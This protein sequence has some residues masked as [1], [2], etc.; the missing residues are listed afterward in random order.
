MRKAHFLAQLAAESGFITMEESFKYNYKS[1]RSAPLKNFNSTNDPDRTRAKEWGYG[2]GERTKEQITNADERSIANWA[3]GKLPKA[4]ELG[5][6]AIT[7]N[8]SDENAD[9]WN[10]R[11]SGFIQ[12]TG[13]SNFKSVSNLYNSWIATDSSGIDKVDLVASPEDLRTDKSI[14]MGAALIYWKNKNLLTRSDMGVGTD[15]LGAITY[16]I[17]NAFAGWSHREPYL[18]KAVEVLKVEECEDYVRRKDQKGSVVVVTGDKNKIVKVKGR[19]NVVY[20]TVVYRSMSLE[21]YNKLKK[22]DILPEPD[23]VTYLTRDTH[24]D[25][26]TKMNIQHSKLRYG[27]HNECPPGD[28]YYLNSK[29]DASGSSYMMYVSDSST[30]SGIE[31]KEELKDLMDK[32]REGIA[33]HQYD[34]KYSVGCLTL[35]SSKDKTPVKAL[36]NAIPDL[37]LHN[38]MKKAKR[39]DENGV[40]HNMNIERRFVRIII[41]EREVTRADKTHE[42]YDQYIWTGI[43]NE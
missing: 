22:D 34:R 8:W 40:E 31:I 27:K 25:S 36:Y 21:N 43:N 30:G 5:N 28:K 9:G 42:N 37:F 19:D 15:A 35:A 12:L 38:V 13:K 1:L 2:F 10:Y 6:T 33:I 20:K 16:N 3:Y 17:N 11:G 18:E 41:E 23:Y 14:A 4:S 24:Q 29:K 32:K 39:V 7:S 26:S